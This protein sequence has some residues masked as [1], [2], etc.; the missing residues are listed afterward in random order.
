MRH[1]TGK[2]FSHFIIK[3]TEKRFFYAKSLFSLF[4]VIYVTCGRSGAEAQ[5]YDCKHAI[6]SSISTEGK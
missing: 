4:K 5:A 1:L 2:R 6:V 3:R